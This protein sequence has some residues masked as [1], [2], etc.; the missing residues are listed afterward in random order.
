MKSYERYI[1]KESE[2]LKRNEQH[3]SLRNK[4]YQEEGKKSWM[5]AISN[6]QLILRSLARTNV[7]KR[8]A[9]EWLT[10]MDDEALW[11][12]SVEESNEDLEGSQLIHKYNEI[13]RQ[14]MK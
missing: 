14:Y 8:D 1:S 6:R 3:S 13:L 5:N 10:K 4:F 12:E 11:N 9:E 2:L 7:V